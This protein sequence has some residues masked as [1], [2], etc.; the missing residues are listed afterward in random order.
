MLELCQPGVV[1]PEVCLTLT[2]HQLYMVVVLTSL[3]PSTHTENVVT[4]PAI[5]PVVPVLVPL[6]PSAVEDEDRQ[7]DIVISVLLVQT[8]LVVIVPDLTAADDVGLA[9]AGG[10]VLHVPVEVLPSDCYHESAQP[11]LAQLT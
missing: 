10:H 9:Q 8:E 5:R 11:S 2:A 6:L 1:I 3:S 4:Q 7:P